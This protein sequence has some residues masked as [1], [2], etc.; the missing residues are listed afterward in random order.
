MHTGNWELNYYRPQTV[1]FSQVSVCPRVC[2]IACWDTH[3]P[4]TRGRHLPR[5]RHPLEQTPSEADIP[6]SRHP[7]RVDT[8]WI[9]DSLGPDTPPK[10]DTP[11]QTPPGS[12]HPR[13][14][15]L[16]Q[17]MLGDTGNKRTVCILLECILVK[18]VD[19]F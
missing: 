4:R 13:E 5:S 16:P 18:K 1:M 8:P 17:C 11:E 9:I 2:P 19:T 7:H 12:R 6:W 15:P 10:A 3:P 14:A